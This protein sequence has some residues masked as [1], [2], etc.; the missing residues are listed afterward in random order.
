MNTAKGERRRKKEKE[1]NL[2]GGVMHE[3]KC[4]HCNKIKVY[5]YKSHI[6]RFCSHSCARKGKPA[7]KVTIKCRICQSNF[8]VTES[9][10]RKREKN[11]MQIKYCSRKC[12]GESKRGGNVKQCLNCRNSFYGTKKKFCAHRCYCEYK[13]KTN[14]K[15]YWFENGYKILYTEDGKGIK[16]HIKIMEEHIG[17]KVNSNEVVHHI[18]EI[19]TD[20]RIENLQ[21]MTRSE[22]SS[23]HRK[24]EIKEGKRLFEKTKQEKKAK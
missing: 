1:L 20:N 9:E 5:Q 18:N 15:G 2:G 24:K 19:K 4:E 12:T 17:R 10:K 11:G 16:E 21:L 14:I 22:H 23:Y 3:S 6:R 8:E 7:K 13:K